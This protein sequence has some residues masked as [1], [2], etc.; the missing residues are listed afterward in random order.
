MNAD[1]TGMLQTLADATRRILFES[2]AQKAQTVG[3]VATLVPVSRSAVSQH[4]K[5]LSQAGL[6][7]GQRNGREVVY[8][9]QPDALRRLAGHFRALAE[10]GGDAAL[11][12]EADERDHVD[13]A[14]ERWRDLWPEYDA[15][16]V[17]LIARLLLIGRVMDR[18][19]ARSAAH[20]GISRVDVIVLG[21]LRRI[22]PPHESTATEL[23][24][25]AVLSLPGMSQRLDHL[26]RSGL[27]KRLPSAQDGRASVV[28]L[29]AKGIAV[30][31]R[32]V[33][34]QMGGNYAAFFELPLPER[35][36]LA[37]SLRRL[38]RQLEATTDRRG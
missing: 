10:V 13:T 29:T 16:T 6:V 7:Q 31:N 12:A 30:N 3:E 23:S 26:E 9:A 20:H 22:G 1:V 11:S 33:H 24:K 27:V 2:L 28:R 19:S 38:L 34:E 18:M 8:A 4:L 37:R 32:V 21:T 15:P 25:T 36:Q 17:A 5:V 14:L 35:A